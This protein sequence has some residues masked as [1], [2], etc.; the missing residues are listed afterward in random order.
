MLP[1]S[2]RWQGGHPL[3]TCVHASS[4]LD[5]LRPM[6][7][8]GHCQRPIRAMAAGF[9]SRV[10]SRWLPRTQE[11]AQ[12]GM[13]LLR[14]EKTELLCRARPLGTG[15][16]WGHQAQW[17]SEPGRKLLETWTSQGKLSSGHPR[18]ERPSSMVRKAGGRQGPLTPIPPPAHLGALNTANFLH[19]DE[20][21]YLSVALQQ[22]L[23]V[24][25]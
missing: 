11:E 3:G 21:V 20:E 1:P 9:T 19:Y 14:G 6:P 22:P 23:N 2:S 7:W 13:Q 24:L 17:A 10:G 18:Q 15:R 12:K 4:F 8:E 16:E 25:G 5:W